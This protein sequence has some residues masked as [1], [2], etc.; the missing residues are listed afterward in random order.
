MKKQNS[1]SDDKLQT[2]ATHHLIDFHHSK[3]IRKHEILSL[4]VYMAFLLQADLHASPQTT[5]LH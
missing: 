2:N 5:Q 4:P 3:L 1:L